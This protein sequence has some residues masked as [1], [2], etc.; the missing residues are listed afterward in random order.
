MQSSSALHQSTILPVTTKPRGN[1]AQR[2]HKVS[3]IAMALS[4][5]FA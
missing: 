3:M 2:S 1:I 4:Q 5:T